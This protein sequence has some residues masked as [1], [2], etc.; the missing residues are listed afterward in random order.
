MTGFLIE[1]PKDASAAIARFPGIDRAQCAARAR[2][3]FA[4]DTMAARYEAVY[5]DA[6]IMKLQQSATDE[7]A[8]KFCRCLRWRNHLEALQVVHRER[9]I[10]GPMAVSFC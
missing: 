10:V 6:R 9:C 4:D 5:R 7:T 3:R 1:R 2:L 8:R